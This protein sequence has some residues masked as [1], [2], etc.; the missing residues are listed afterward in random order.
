MLKEASASLLET[1]D[2]LE[3]VAVAGEY[4]EG[5]E[6][7]D[8]ETGDPKLVLWLGS[9]IGNFDADGAAGFLQNLIRT[10]SRKDRL[11]IGFDLVKDREVLERAYNDSAGVTARFNLNL[12]RRI[13]RDLGGEFDLKSFRHDAIYNEKKSRVE[14][15]LVSKEEQ[16]VRIDALG[17]RFH[18]DRGERIHT[19]NSHK[20][21]PW[22]IRDLACRVGLDIVQRWSDDHEYFSLT[23]FKVRPAGQERDRTDD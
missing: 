21:S 15:Y 10:M 19:E 13:N 11:L 5:L 14:M 16:D 9:S 18:F 17:T 4:C 3:V 8:T 1:Y 7:L 12:L 22:S 20:F 6:R 23:M 2:D